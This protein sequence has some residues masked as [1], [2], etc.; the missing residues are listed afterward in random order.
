MAD[1]YSI[2]IQPGSVSIT[3]VADSSVILST[4]YNYLHQDPAGTIVWPVNQTLS[5]AGGNL[6][7]QF[8]GQQIVLQNKYYAAGAKVFDTYV[9]PM[10]ALNPTI[11]ADGFVDY[12]AG[13][14]ES[15]SNSV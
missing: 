9:I 10:K 6:T 3:R 8:N 2:N 12:A 13:N 5:S 15:T 1:T 7:W 4:D 14:V 11:T